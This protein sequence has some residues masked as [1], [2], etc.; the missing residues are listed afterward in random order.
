M[1]KWISRRHQGSA[2]RQPSQLINARQVL[3]LPA[4]QVGIALV[5]LWR[6]PLGDAP[7][8]ELRAPEV[9]PADQSMI[10]LPFLAPVDAGSLDAPELEFGRVRARRD[11]H[12]RRFHRRCKGVKDAE[13]DHFVRPAVESRLRAGRYLI[14]AILDARMWKNQDAAGAQRLP[15]P[16]RFASFQALDCATLAQFRM[17]AGVKRMHFLL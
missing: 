16:P 8:L 6:V 17:F 7:P 4:R 2:F 5:N 13:H 1:M 12:A 14:A 15:Q 3:R 10:A 11:R 9:T